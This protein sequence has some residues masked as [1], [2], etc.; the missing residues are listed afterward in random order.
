[1]AGIKKS[2]IPFVM[3]ALIC[4]LIGV[5]A[6]LGRL[7][8][9]SLSF[10]A[11]VHHGGIMIGGFLGTLITLEK[12]IPLKKK[13]L[14]LFPVLS[15]L[16]VF[17]FLLSLPRVGFILLVGASSGLS[18]VFLLYC[19]KE[20]AVVYLLMLGGSIS[21]TI[22]NILLLFNQLYPIALTWWMGFTLFIISAERLELMKFLPVTKNQ[23]YVFIIFL[24][25]FPIGALTSFHGHGGI[26]A[27]SSLIC[28]AIWLLKFDLI[29]I[30]LHKTGLTK[31]VA[32]ALLAGYV[33]LLITGVFL[34][35]FNTQAFAYDVTIHSFFLGFVFSMIFAHGPIILPGVIGSSA[36]AFHPI[37]YTWLVLLHASWLI[38]AVG[39]V[40]GVLDCRMASGIISVVAMLGYFATLITLLARAINRQKIPVKHSQQFS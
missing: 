33:S 38:R 30:T 31:F 3:L 28:C 23:K 5:T 13:W 22:G 37:L 17:F 36:K 1:M 6:G 21:W 34:I 39:G 11:M 7:G 32:N 12:I 16:S 19:L 26:V 27:G 18:L 4:L 40:M 24:I 8:W 14:Y 25:A 9:T 10:P 35:N 15:A 20:R 2:R 29:G